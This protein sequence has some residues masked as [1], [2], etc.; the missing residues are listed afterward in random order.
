MLEKNVMERLAWLEAVFTHI[1]PRV[2]SAGPNINYLTDV[3]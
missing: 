1:D 2:S 3:S